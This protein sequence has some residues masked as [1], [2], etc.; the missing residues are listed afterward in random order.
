MFTQ[1]SSGTFWPVGRE[2]RPGRL[3]VDAESK[4]LADA[5]ANRLTD[6]DF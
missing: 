4:R 1:W 2:V 6:G 3:K 5:L